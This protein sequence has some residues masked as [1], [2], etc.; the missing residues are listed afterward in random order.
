[1]AVSGETLAASGLEVASYLPLRNASFTRSFPH[2]L[3]SC[4]SRALADAGLL[5]GILKV[6]Q[7]FVEF[8]FLRVQLIEYIIN[9]VNCIV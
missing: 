7:L 1:M 8:V 5:S 9:L 2:L 6:E 3:L 4:S